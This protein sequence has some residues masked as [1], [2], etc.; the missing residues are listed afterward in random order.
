[1]NQYTCLLLVPGSSGKAQAAGCESVL[2]KH[3]NLCIGLVTL[4]FSAG[5]ANPPSEPQV[6]TVYFW[7]QLGH[8][9]A[10]GGC[11][12]LLI[13]IRNLDPG[14]RRRR[15]LEHRRRLWQSRREPSCVCLASVRPNETLPTSA[16]LSLAQAERPRLTMPECDPR[17]KCPEKRR[18][19]QVSINHPVCPGV[20]MDVIIHRDPF[21]KSFYSISIQHC[22]SRSY[23]LP[24]TIPAKTEPLRPAAFHCIGGVSKENVNG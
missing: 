21:I 15:C 23:C 2:F 19:H 17:G 1:M 11:D 20:R 8:Q 9:G 13:A 14:W 12:L 4:N 16:L 24:S 10:P 22:L 6:L 5:R 7:P 3:T 18:R